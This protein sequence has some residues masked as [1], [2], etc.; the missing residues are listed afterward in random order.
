MKIAQGIPQLFAIYLLSSCSV[1]SQEAAQPTSFDFFGDSYEAVQS[2]VIDRFQE[3][4]EAEDAMAILAMARKYIASTS[5][6]EQR[7]GIELAER[8]AQLGALEAN[9]LL[10]D[11][12]RRGGF[13]IAPD[14]AKAKT[15]LEAALEEGATSAAVSLG[16]LYL[17]T[18][19]SAEGQDRG[20]K[21][22]QSA[23][24]EGSIEAANVLG[25]LYIQGRGVSAD[26]ARAFEYYGVGLV[27]NQNSTIVALGDVLRSGLRRSSPDPDLALDFFKKASEQGEVGA[28]RRIADMHLRG[29][30]VPQDIPG[31]IN[32][33]AALASAG[34]TNSDIALGDIFARGEFVPVDS[35]RAVRHYQ[36][37]ADQGNLA[38]TM[39]L[40]EIH[41]TGLPGLASNFGQALAL[42]TQASDLGN[43]AA[44]RA[45]AQAYLTGRFGSIDPMRAVE[46]LEEAANLGDGQAAQDLATLYASNEPFPANFENVRRYLE[47]AL[48][49]GNA[50]AA[51][52]VASAIVRGPLSRAHRQDARAILDGAINGGVPGASA[53]LA[54]LQLEGAFPADGVTGIVGLLN[55]AALD[56]DVEAA[57]FLLELYRDGYGLLLP[58]NLSAATEFL[59]S[60]QDQLGPEISTV[61]RIHLAAV[62]GDHPENVE[63][64]SRQFGDLSQRSAIQVLDI[65]RRENARAYVYILQ[66]R[67]LERGKYSGRVSGTLDSQTIRAINATCAELGAQA[68]CAPGPLTR[69]TVLTIGNYILQPPP[70][71]SQGE[72]A[73]V[74][75]SGTTAAP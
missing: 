29:E 11:V 6:E 56:G 72:A 70:L 73:D 36:T 18:D 64:I 63:A 46:L 48:A 40:A 15:F 9:L 17:A 39:R 45:L 44:K 65:L 49:V 71:P 47:V 24:Q 41:A 74:S 61:E 23:A 62:Q 20:I 52:T 42:Y 5:T 59:D 51:L 75:G 27:S 31:A 22:I 69:G 38:G 21:M 13:G 12:Y 53:T 1:W 19:F 4:I 3:L 58:P 14:L 25:S 35:A 28:D 7:Q 50:D 34:D 68:T 30:A 54:R 67:L 8:A 55:Q 33:L 16:Q 37:A 57:R 66:Q 10:G 26:L 43:P 2:T 60:V 32:M